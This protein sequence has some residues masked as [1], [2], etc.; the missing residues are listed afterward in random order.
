MTWILFFQNNAVK[1][2]VHTFPFTFSLFVSYCIQKLWSHP[3]IILRT[4][5]CT[6]WYCHCVCLHV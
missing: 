4:F 1:N 2:I 6:K 5:W 3:L